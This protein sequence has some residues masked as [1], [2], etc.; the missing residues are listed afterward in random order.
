MELSPIIDAIGP[1]SGN[2]VLT[3]STEDLDSPNLTLNHL[4]VEHRR[5]GASEPQCLDRGLVDLPHGIDLA[6]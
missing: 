5:P 6:V 4:Y 1:K 2:I 3:E